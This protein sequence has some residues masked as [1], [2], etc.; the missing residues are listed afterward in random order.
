VGVPVEKAAAIAASISDD[1]RKEN[2]FPPEAADVSD[3]IE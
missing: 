1:Q 3:K 2:S